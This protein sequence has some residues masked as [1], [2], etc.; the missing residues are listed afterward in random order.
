[1]VPS[2]GE[3]GLRREE[4]YCGQVMDMMGLEWA[5]GWMVVQGWLGLKMTLGRPSV[6]FA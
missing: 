4:M 6:G 1:M 5:V 2:L 3:L